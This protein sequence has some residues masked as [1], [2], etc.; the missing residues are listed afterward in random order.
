VASAAGAPFADAN[1]S[2]RFFNN[3]VRYRFFVDFTAVR[4]C[5]HPLAFAQKPCLPKARDN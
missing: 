5:N 3:N 1:N 4:I 2:P